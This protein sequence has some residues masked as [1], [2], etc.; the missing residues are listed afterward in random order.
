M[1]LLVFAN[2]EC[3]FQK[4]KKIKSTKLKC[5][6]RTLSYNTTSQV[7]NVA[8]LISDIRDTLTFVR[9]LI[10]VYWHSF[11]AVMDISCAFLRVFHFFYSFYILVDRIAL[12][13][14][15]SIAIEAQNKWIPGLKLVCITVWIFKGRVKT[16]KCH[17]NRYVCAKPSIDTCWPYIKDL[18]IKFYTEWFLNTFQKLKKSFRR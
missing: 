3:I 1:K 9:I 12:H 6:H 15:N 5:L 7:L 8:L 2:T 16:G 4:W 11:I 17:D 13:L 10:V 14:A 18:E